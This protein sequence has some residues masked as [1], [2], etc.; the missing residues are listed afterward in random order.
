[1]QLLNV[2]T[3]FSLAS[4]SI[5]SPLHV[6]SRQDNGSSPCAAVSA[7]VATQTSAAIPTV[8]AQLAYECITSVPLN[9][10][11]A[12]AL[13]KSIRPYFRWQSTTAYLKNPP[14]EYIEKIQNP[15]DIW[16][17]LDEIEKN[18]T[19]GVWTQEYEFGWSLYHLLQSTHD[20]HFVYVPDVVGTVFNFARPVPLVS[21][22][23][24][25]TSL[26][27]PFVYP[28]I[29][30]T[31]LGNAS[32]SPSPVVSING[33]DATTYL[34]NWSQFGSLQDRDALYNNVFYELAVVSLGSSGSG[35][36]TFAGGGRGRWVYPGP[37]TELCFANGTTVTYT[38]FAKVLIP[39]D[40][41]TSGESL[42]ELWFPGPQ[43]SATSASSAASS[44]ASAA[45]STSP[46]AAPIST[47]APGYPNPVVRQ[48]NNLIGGYYLE[49]DEYSDVAV[50]SV[51]SFVSLDSAEISFQAVGKQ[52]ISMA[53]AAGK[54][55]LIVDVSANG[56]G[57][58]LQGYDLFKQLFPSILP[59]GANRF[60]AFES[61]DLLGK[62]FSAI[63]SQ[64]PRTL[65][66]TND[67]LLQVES[68]V[69]SSVFNYRT[70]V[71]INYKNFPSWKAKYG[72]QHHHGDSFTN[73]IRW[74]LSD[75]L[76]PLNSGGIYITGYDNNTVVTQPFA[77]ADVIIVTDGY[78]ASTC[79]IF[80]ELMRQQAGVKTVAMGG[81]ARAGI[82]QAV[83]GVKGTNDLPWDYIQYLV[84]VAFNYSTPE[85]AA[86]YNKTQ[87]GEY[88]S[89]LPFLRAAI[90]SSHNVNFR[91]GI[92]QGDTS[93]EQIPLQF[94]YEP[95]DC[96]ILY[97]PEMTVDATEIWKAVAD[98]AWK[99]SNKCV[100]GNV[101]VNSTGGYQKRRSSG[102]LKRR[103]WNV[104]DYPL[105]VYTDLRKSKLSGD[106]IMLP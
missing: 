89:D 3:A 25:G 4:I 20:G 81:R 73:I 64:Y 100:A 98:S 43:P 54:T 96:R 101:A 87:L 44:L 32:F 94:K 102:S 82:S 28:D 62:K 93:A 16:D 78:C 48:Q 26:P 15:V 46:S 68:D 21:V 105:D 106:A 47:P 7:S 66:T 95:A 31:S 29:L 6:Y 14:A 27:K 50:L 9:V 1:M 51:P 10:S 42:Y 69:V 12:V 41:I 23:E 104:E 86:H 74:N 63:S 8:P 37:T 79:T 11:A 88:Y 55:K 13:V 34:E 97:T 56:G 80:S 49:G 72:P 76:T 90:G 65:D 30:A 58:I 24:D 22:S 5:A 40:G 17:G 103:A 70:D 61:T 19:S 38:N 2:F 77:A 83:G 35:M 85:E 71:D 60:R 36:G 33:E 75:V 84:Q 67:T 91:D 99:G 39:F 52:F 45:P 57:T 18:L 53:R 92:R 59:Y